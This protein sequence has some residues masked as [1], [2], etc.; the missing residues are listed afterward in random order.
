MQW[1]Q[2]LAGFRRF[3]KHKYFKLQFNDRLKITSVGPKL[4]DFSLK[5]IL[6]NQNVDTN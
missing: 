1:V 3:F 2:I 5:M 4:P 6:V